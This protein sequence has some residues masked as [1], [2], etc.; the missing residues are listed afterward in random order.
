[1]TIHHSPLPDVVIPDVPITAHVL[2]EAARVPDRAAI[3][4][5]P[6]RPLLHLRTVRRGRGGLR[7]RLDGARHGA[8]RHDRA[9]VSEHPGVRHRLSRCG[10]SRRG[11]QHHQSDVHGGGSRLSTPRLTSSML[12]TIGMFAETATAAVQEAD[13]SEIFIIGDAPEGMQPVTA[14]HG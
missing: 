2:R 3:V 10:D 12:V 5:G 1:M 6:N 8:G 9:D 13:V 4:D 14:L 11:R 7:R